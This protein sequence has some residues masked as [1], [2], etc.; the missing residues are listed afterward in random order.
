MLISNQKSLP[1]NT[2]KHLSKLKT[3]THTHKSLYNP[4]IASKTTTTK[5]QK[6]VWLFWSRFWTQ[7]G[8]KTLDK[9]FC[10]LI[11]NQR[12]LRQI[13]K[14]YLRKKYYSSDVKFII[15]Y[16]LNLRVF[17]KCMEVYTLHKQYQH[18]LICDRQQHLQS[19]LMEITGVVIASA[20]VVI[21]SAGVWSCLWGCHCD[22]RC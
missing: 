19:C 6:I 7:F 11:S 5:Q 14:H 17:M 16:Y 10:M 1:M 2:C 21:V 22:F 18:I 3:C 15:V 12:V 9:T 20:G 4:T 8:W 13:F